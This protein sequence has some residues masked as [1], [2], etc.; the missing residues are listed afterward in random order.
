MGKVVVPVSQGCHEDQGNG[1]QHNI[2]TQMLA[3]I[4]MIMVRIY[5][6]QLLSPLPK[7]VLNKTK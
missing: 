2:R 5:S 3:A 7:T 6:V 4:I 1:A